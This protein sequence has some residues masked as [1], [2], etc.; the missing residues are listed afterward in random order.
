MVEDELV[1]YEG[2]VVVGANF[3]V[4]DHVQIVINHLII[5]KQVIIIHLLPHHVLDF[6]GHR[7]MVHGLCKISLLQL[8]H[9]A[10]SHHPEVGYGEV[11]LA[12]RVAHPGGL[13][14][15]GLI[16][17]RVLFDE[18]PENLLLE[19]LLV[20]Q[21]V[22]IEGVI[23]ALHALQEIAHVEFNSV[24]EVLLAIHVLSDAFLVLQ[25]LVVGHRGVLLYN[26]D[27]VA[28]GFSPFQHRRDQLSRVDEV[29]LDFVPGNL[30]ESVH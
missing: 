4:V 2:H 3:L 15:L 1:V 26:L 16:L 9:L 11:N 5:I 24:N 8:H 23:L 17:T 6:G 13:E 7:A 18:L 14:Q 10:N 25:F 12:L 22:L 20:L 29:H 30:T 27:E 21:L 19:H 28:E